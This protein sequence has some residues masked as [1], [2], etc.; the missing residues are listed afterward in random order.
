MRQLAT[1]EA[2]IDFSC[3]SLWSGV[4]P[5]RILT[6][7]LLPQV[8]LSSAQEEIHGEASEAGE[9]GGSGVIPDVVGL[10]CWSAP[11]KVE[12]AAVV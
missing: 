10:G 6:V 2:Y 8:L 7:V 11:A 12:L 4:Q 1:D 5:R 9:E 3:V